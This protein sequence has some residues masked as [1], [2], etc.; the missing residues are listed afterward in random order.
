MAVQLSNPSAQQFMQMQ[1][2]AAPSPGVSTGAQAPAG[3]AATGEKTA[4]ERLGNF[5]SM[6]NSMRKQVSKAAGNDGDGAGEALPTLSDEELSH[7]IAPLVKGIEHVRTV[8][9]SMESELAQ[10]DVRGA[11]EVA[12]KAVANVTRFDPDLVLGADFMDGS[13]HKALQ[14]YLAK[15]G[16]SSDAA[17]ETGEGDSSAE[18]DGLP[19]NALPGEGAA[20]AVP[21]GTQ[22]AAKNTDAAVDEELPFDEIA[23]FREE[24]ELFGLQDGAKLADP[25]KSAEN[26]PAGD[27]K[28]RISQFPGGDIAQQANA[29]SGENA[30]GKQGGSSGENT[31]PRAAKTS[32][33]SANAKGQKTAQTGDTLARAGEAD[34]EKKSDFAESFASV[35]R[36]TSENR[37]ENRS[38]VSAAMQPGTSYTLPGDDAFGEGL[39]SVLTFMKDEGT[40]EARIVVEPPALGRIDVS[41]QAS[42]SGVEAVFKVDN[43]HLKQMLQ[44]QMDLLKTS[45]QAQG[46]HVSGLAVDIKNRDDQRGRGDLYGT[47]KKIRRM[48]GVD[49][50]DEDLA[51]GTRLVRLDLEKGLLHWLA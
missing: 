3:S 41:L 37:V 39:S 9:D 14:E 35:L 33:L 42:S 46:I 5:G 48:G 44:Q 22:V 12:K 32:Q 29:A 1:A 13:L 47:N 16:I 17:A 43:E 28:D 25:R 40:S 45:L 50:A 10:G 24:L 11:I 30:S 36:G 19:G 38:P 23:R 8:A 34:G 2:S 49:A 51:E 15:N 4:G 6:L 27:A 18:T 7:L 26:D 31:D 21:A 20:E